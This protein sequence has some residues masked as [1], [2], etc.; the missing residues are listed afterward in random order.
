MGAGAP[1][2]HIEIERPLKVVPREV[3]ELRSDDHAVIARVPRLTRIKA[4][5]SLV[6]GG[7]GHRRD[8]SAVGVFHVQKSGDQRT[9]Q[10]CRDTKFHGRESPGRGR[11]HAPR[12]RIQRRPSRRNDDKRLLVRFQERGTI[13]VTPLRVNAEPVVLSDIQRKAKLAIGPKPA[14][15]SARIKENGQSAMRRIPELFHEVEKCLGHQT[16]TFV[17]QRDVT[18]CLARTSMA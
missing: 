17:D 7:H 12:T 3:L 11:V 16:A 9:V 2:E 18:R 6:I 13:S 15:Y 4:N 5:G 8:G 1:I 14:L 10:R